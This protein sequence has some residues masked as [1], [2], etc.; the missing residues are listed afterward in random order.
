MINYK[1]KY[2]NMEYVKDNY[3]F[4]ILSQ[5]HDLDSFECE[6]EDLNNFLKNDALKQQKLNLNLTLLVLCDDVVLVLYPF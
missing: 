1:N 2:M 4:E 5:K 3:T 6:S